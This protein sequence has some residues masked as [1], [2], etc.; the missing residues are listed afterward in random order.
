MLL[1]ERGV[2]V[3]VEL[4][5]HLICLGQG[6]LCFGLQKL[7]L[8]LRQ[9]SVGLREL[10][11]RVIERRLKRARINLKEQLVLPDR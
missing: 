2:A 5:S 4:G 10:P 9:L 11:Q 3:F 6:N 7:R 1:H 8:C